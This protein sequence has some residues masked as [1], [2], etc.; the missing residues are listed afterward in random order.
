V[1]LFAG[2]FMLAYVG[3]AWRRYDGA[4]AIAFAGLA[5]MTIAFA[6]A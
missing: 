6:L 3:V 1:L 4:I 5:L 2:T